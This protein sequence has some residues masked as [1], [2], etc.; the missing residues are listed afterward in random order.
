MLFVRTLRRLTALTLLASLLLV[1]AVAATPRVI[2]ISLDGA[3]PHLIEEYTAAGALDPGRGLGRLASRGVVARRNT[4]VSPSLTAPGHI[5]IATGSTAAHNDVPANTFHLVASPFAL[6]I[7]G[8][9]SP[10]GGYAIDGPAESRAVT[11]EP[12]WL[13]LRAAGKTVVTATFPGGDGVDVRVPG[14]PA[15]TIVQPAAERTVDVTVPFGAFGGIGARGLALTAADFAAAPATTTTQLAA[16]GRAS[17]SPVM[18]ATAPLETFTVGGATF[19]MHVAALDTSDDGTANYDTLVFFDATHGIQPGPF[20]LP[21]TGPAYVRAADRRASLFYLEGSSTRAGTSFHVSHLAPDLSTVRIA[22]MSAG[23]IPRNAAVL[24]D[25]DDINTHVGFW[26]P[27]P[28]FR[29]HRGRRPAARDRSLPRGVEAGPARVVVVDAEGGRLPAG[30]PPSS[31]LHAA[32]GRRVTAPGPSCKRMRPDTDRLGRADLHVHSAWSDGRQPPESLVLAAAGR[33]D[34]L[35]LTD[36]DEIEGAL[37]ARAFARSRPELGVDVIVGEEVSTLNGHLLGLYIEERVAPGLTA[38][39]TIELIHA[40]GGLAVAPHPL[41]PIRYAR[42]GHRPLAEMVADLPLDAV[43]VVNNTGPLACFYDARALVAND[44]WRLP[45]CGGSDAHDTRYVGS[46]LTRFEG[47]SAEALRRALVAGRSHAHLNWSWTLGGVPV[48][49]G[50]KCA[51]F[52]RFVGLG[53]GDRFA[54]A[55]PRRHDG[56]TPG[57]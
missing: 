1:D 10:I 13:A 2:V 24:A 36:H 20:T 41:H 17:F 50:L 54:E 33:V 23:F 4:T 51:D 22:R 16:A 38:E 57:R 26:A 6:N 35:A 7:S 28:D 30:R 25:V 11:A 44:R 46:G 40:Q 21:A 37:R 39:R 15:A 45:V 48:H 12:L 52:L 3:T 53:L 29:G 49:V 5:A 27:Q 34:L 56:A 43:E 18:Q 42:R 14:D 47:R 32:E 9:G 8:F 55:S 19:T 31:T